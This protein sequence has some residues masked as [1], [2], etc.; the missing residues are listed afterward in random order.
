MIETFL[1]AFSALFSVVNPLGAMP[2]FLMLTTGNTRPERRGQA[3]RIAIFMI[4][5]LTVFFFAG[6]LIL[7]FF[8][9][10]IDHVRIAG[11]L[12]IC[13]SAM[14]L[15]GKEAYKGKPLAKEVQEEGIQKEDI[16]FTPMAMPLLSGPGAIAL[17]ISIYGTASSRGFIGVVGILL[18]ILLVAVTTFLILIFSG[19]L[20]RFLGKGGM[21]AL[22]RMMGFITLSIGISMI[23]NG[24]VSVFK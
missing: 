9:I 18:A 24:L 15:L 13:S 20:N 10:Q 1:A 11:G 3:I 21:A 8:G 14:T 7:N 2:V 4:L 16:T 22:S 5:I 19:Q 12:L 17:M 6:N 23:L